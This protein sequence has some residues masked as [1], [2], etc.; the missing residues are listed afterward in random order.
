MSI[1]DVHLPPIDHVDQTVRLFGGL[2]KWETVQSS[3]AMCLRTIVRNCSDNEYD[4]DW[5]I[6]NERY[7]YISNR[8]IWVSV[9]SLQLTW[10]MSTVH[11]GNERKMPS[12]STASITLL[13]SILC[14]HTYFIALLKWTKKKMEKSWCAREIAIISPNLF[15]LHMS[16]LSFSHYRSWI[17]THTRKLPSINEANWAVTR[18]MILWTILLLISLSMTI[19]TRLTT[20]I[21]CVLWCHTN[22][23]YRFVDMNN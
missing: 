23:L 21:Y 13:H 16:D 9:C 2:D 3:N 20:S 8:C 15:F 18:F 22:N 6:V 1:W 5:D 4:G 7:D 11:D 17:H 19:W 14:F 12:R 10:H